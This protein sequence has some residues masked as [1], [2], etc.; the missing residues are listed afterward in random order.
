MHLPEPIMKSLNIASMELRAGVLVAHHKL[1]AAK[2][3]YADAAKQEKKIGY[4]EPP[5]YIRPVAET[6]AAALLKAKDYKDA[7][8]AYEAALVARPNS[9][10]ELYGLALV[11]EVF[12]QCC[13]GAPSLRGISEGVAQCGC[14][15]SGSAHAQMIMEPARRPRADLSVWRLR[16]L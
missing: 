1:R 8:T 2:K 6:E 4:H 7:A 12:R 16:S 3:L 5:F 11:K 15:P 13:R 10:F 14:E 9:G